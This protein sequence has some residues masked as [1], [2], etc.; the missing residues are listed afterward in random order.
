MSGGRKELMAGRVEHP[1]LWK[2]GL[3][4]GANDAETFMRARTRGSP[5]WRG[6]ERH[7]AGYVCARPNKA[8]NPI[9]NGAG[10]TCLNVHPRPRSQA[11]HQLRLI[12]TCRSTETG[13]ASCRERVCHYVENA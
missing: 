8:I 9:A 5:S 2:P 1:R 4:N 10:H 12:F 7:Y 13:R 11:P 3:K 6:P